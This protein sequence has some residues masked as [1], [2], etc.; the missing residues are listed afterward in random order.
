MIELLVSYAHSQRA[1][2]I[3]GEIKSHDF[4]RDPNLPEWYRRRGFSVVMGKGA[5]VATITY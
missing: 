4:Q 1:K 2:R 5:G 3:E